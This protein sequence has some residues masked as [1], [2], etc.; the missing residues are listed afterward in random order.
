MYVHIEET[1]VLP[2]EEPL[3][4]VLKWPRNIYKYLYSINSTALVVK[5]VVVIVVATKMY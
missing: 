1:L 5:L 4:L 2:K 3:S